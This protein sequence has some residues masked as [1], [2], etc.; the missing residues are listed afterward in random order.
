MRGEGYVRLHARKV[1]GL[2]GTTPRCIAL[3]R[4]IHRWA[5]AVHVLAPSARNPPFDLRLV[6]LELCSERAKND[7]R[8]AALFLC[9]L[10]F[11]E[12]AQFRRTT[13]AHHGEALAT[14]F[15]GGL[16]GHINVIRLSTTNCH[17]DPESKPL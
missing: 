11:D 1:F 13:K 10:G 3:L 2:A 9:S 5:K 16:A 12:S 4:L 14:L 17:T 8:F 6:A 7:L 15:R